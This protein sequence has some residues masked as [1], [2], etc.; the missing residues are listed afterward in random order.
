MNAT[1][2]SS[3]RLLSATLAVLFQM[4]L[5]AEAISIEE[6]IATAS[7]HCGAC[8]SIEGY[9]DCPECF[10][11]E[12]GGCS[13][14]LCTGNLVL[15]E[16]PTGGPSVVLAGAYNGNHIGSESDGCTV[17]ATPL[18]IGWKYRI[19]GRFRPFASASEADI[20]TIGIDSFKVL[21]RNPET[22]DP[23]RGSF[24]EGTAADRIVY[25]FD[26]S[27]GGSWAHLKSIKPL[28]TLDDAFDTLDRGRFKGRIVDGAWNGSWVAWYGNGKIK[29][30]G[31][32]IADAKDGKWREFDS[33]GNTISDGLFL[34]GQE[35]G[36][37][38][39]AL[40]SNGPAAEF[41]YA[42][43]PDKVVITEYLSDSSIDARI[44]VD[45]R[46][47]TVERF[48]TF[49]RNGK[50]KRLVT[51][52][53]VSGSARIEEWLENGREICKQIYDGGVFTDSLWFAS[54]KLW[55]AKKKD[56][57]E[58]PTDFREWHENGA[59]AWSGGFRG[60]APQGVWT[61]ADAQGRRDEAIAFVEGAPADSFLPVAADSG[62]WT[63]FT[64]ATA[65]NALT[66]VPE[67]V[68]AGTDGGACLLSRDG[69]LFK[70]ITTADGLPGNKVTALA[71]D[72]KGN[73]WFGTEHGA[74]LTEVGGSACCIT[75][76][77]EPL[78]RLAT[79]NGYLGNV[80]GTKS[81]DRAGKNHGGEAEYLLGARSPEG[82]WRYDG[83]VDNDQYAPAISSIAVSSDGTVWQSSLNGVRCN[84]SLLGKAMLDRLSTLIG[85]M[86]LGSDSSLWILGSDSVYR[87]K[88]DSIVGYRPGDGASAGEPIAM[89]KGVDGTLYLLADKG[90]FIFQ[91]D[92]FHK[93]IAFDSKAAPVHTSFYRDHDG[94]FLVAT[95]RGIE[96]IS[97]NGQRIVVG[98]GQLGGAEITSFIED[99]S[100]FWIGTKS[101]L[102]RATP[103]G[104]H[105]SDLPEGP[106]GNHAE[107]VR[108]DP[109]HGVWI[110][111]KGTGIYHYDKGAWSL[112]DMQSK[113]PNCEAQ[114]MAPDRRGGLW[115][116]TDNGLVHLSAA[117]GIDSGNCA[118]EQDGSISSTTV[119]RDGALW[120]V[121]SGSTIV[122][123]DGTKSR[124]RY[125]QPPLIDGMIRAF[126]IDTAGA[127]WVSNNRG[128]VVVKNGTAVATFTSA[129][130]LP[131]L[132]ITRLFIGSEGAVYAASLQTVYRLN[133]SL[134]RS[135]FTEDNING[136]MVSGIAQDS[137]GG[138]WVGTKNGLFRFAGS[139]MERYTQRSGLIG[140]SINDVAVDNEGAVWAA[141]GQGI[142]RFAEHTA[143]TIGTFKNSVH[144]STGSPRTAFFFPEI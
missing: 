84:N 45:R 105:R 97:K 62:K 12:S 116:G 73:A 68:W 89:A 74:R 72:S 115:V 75:F 47:S 16:S 67:G 31:A 76:V 133:G 13:G 77:G 56:I 46:F 92:K 64:N 36:V 130:G 71:P 94:S 17:M 85:R 98:R 42:R 112:F 41:D 19:W 127:L 124:T 106:R 91:V 44:T 96:R 57:S 144:G 51:H 50:T 100:T 10:Q 107:M 52:D 122:S 93:I 134:W 118:P 119:D 11:I 110:F 129:N 24:I 86:D 90:I 4:P 95:V 26:D 27:T 125:E 143:A 59:L 5:S 1:K 2:S 87:I 37:W 104:V 21:E 140:S 49:Y 78:A 25:T 40:S 128:I 48:E 103:A 22:F 126:A 54:G 53:P 139:A 43:Q 55:K 82:T 35:Q 14:A 29:A 136:S 123:F 65:V 9:A 34:K 101:G 7:H 109:G 61:H 132:P 113:C 131:L 23:G 28:Q 3:F 135:I 70:K 80:A 117:L 79:Q 15:Q 120:Y 38:K 32:Y 81:G 111:V 83:I 20:Y 6:L 30:Q 33:S 18:H 99:S 66:A 114:D 121:K 142:S 63:A 39:R 138:L 137:K 60:F 102:Y 69:T 8:V 58:A 141:T 88:G 108:T